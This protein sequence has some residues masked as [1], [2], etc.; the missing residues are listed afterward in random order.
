MTTSA[1]EFLAECKS[2]L[3]YREKGDN[4]TIFGEWI[5]HNP[6]QWCDSFLS[7]CAHQVHASDTIGKFSNTVAHAEW[8]A[9]NGRF[10]HTPRVGAIVFYDW[11][12]SGR[13]DNITHAGALEA[14]TV[15]NYAQAIEGNTGDMVARRLRNLA[16]VVGYGYPQYVPSEPPIML[17]LRF[18]DSGAGVFKL[19]RRLNATMGISLDIDGEFGERTLRAVKMFQTLNNLKADGIVGPLTWRM[20]LAK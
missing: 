17:T 5:G 4:Y 6:G 19:Q 7:Y 14:L 20:L 11:N 13:I 8:F 10:G 12:K 16:Y 18:G 15:D 2:Y 9:G 1:R 3:G